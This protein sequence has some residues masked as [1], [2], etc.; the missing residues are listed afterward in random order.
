MAGSPVENWWTN[1]LT[2]LTA[3]LVDFKTA[4][5]SRGYSFYPV[6]NI[7]TDTNYYVHN[8]NISKTVLWT[9][10]YLL[11]LICWYQILK[12]IS[13]A[14]GAG[15][16]HSKKKWDATQP[17][18]LNLFPLCSCWSVYLGVV[19]YTSDPDLQI[20][21]SQRPLNSVSRKL[22]PKHFNKKCFFLILW[23]RGP[24]GEIRL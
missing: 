17:R 19:V 20:R 5:A 4:S 21:L 3:I 11:S 7:F 9:G 8:F 15:R 24:S 23:I 13:Q 1:K 18:T 22:S 16:W 14:I 12:N 2:A 10:A 6:Q